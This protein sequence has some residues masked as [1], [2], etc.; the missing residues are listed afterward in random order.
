MKIEGERDEFS[1]RD[2][3]AWS[4]RCRLYFQQ[5]THI[6]PGRMEKKSIVEIFIEKDWF[7]CRRFVMETGSKIYVMEDVTLWVAKLKN[8]HWFLLTLHVHFNNSCCIN[9][10][11]RRDFGYF[12]WTKTLFLYPLPEITCLWNMSRNEWKVLRDF[13]ELWL[14]SLFQEQIPSRLDLEALWKVLHWNF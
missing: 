14:K 13:I 1:R 4:V 5:R 12:L 6:F 3:L 8:V 9:F 2:W 7:F 10:W 11:M